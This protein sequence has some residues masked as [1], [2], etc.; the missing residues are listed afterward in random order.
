M[1]F[2]KSASSSLV[3]AFCFVGLL[4][5]VVAGE[6]ASERSAAK[7]RL[8]VIVHGSGSVVSSPA[9]ISCPGRCSSL[10]RA[11]TRVRLSARPRAGSKLLRWGGACKL[12]ASCRVTVRRSVLVTAQ[13]GPKT[14]PPPAL[15]LPGSYS[16]SNGQ[17]GNPFDFWLAPGGKVVRNFTDQLTGL[18]CTNGSGASDQ[19]RFLEIPVGANGA[20]SA[21]TSYSGIFRS[22]QA[23]FKFTVNGRLQGGKTSSAAGTWR[24]DITTSDPSISCTSNEQSWTATRDPGPV[25]TKP[26]I[27]PGNYNGQN[28]QNGNG[29]TFTVAA[30]GKSLQNVT[31]PLTG[32]GC[33]DKSGASDHLRL[34]NVAIAP[35]GT[36]SATA[37]QDGLFRTLQATFTYTFTGSFEGQTR[38]GAATVAGLWR[39]DI[40]VPSQPTHSCTSDL[41]P[42]TVTR[43]S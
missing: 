16:G 21:S 18:S 20:F 33:L 34:L 31:D 6:A 1:P 5:L 26:V 12:A 13:F 8:T 39:E 7:A 43:T 10:Y 9:G 30:D 22:L 3:F 2:G 4:A 35:D 14:S 41:Q 36:F 19:M 23:T 15:A 24:E 40:Q 25:P 32:L 42:F 37:S 17:N 38:A 29:F 27:E 28:G 11:G